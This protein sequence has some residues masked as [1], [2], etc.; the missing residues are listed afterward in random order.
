MV[1]GTK[2]NLQKKKKTDSLFTR[3]NKW[4]HL[5]LGLASGVIVL[6]VCITA[7]IWVFNEEITALLEPET[8][9]EKQD[10]A[11]LTDR[12]SVV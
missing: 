7:C 11:V 12:K 5:W 8:K 10:K 6:I 4:L 1:T 2:Q 9:V 3:I